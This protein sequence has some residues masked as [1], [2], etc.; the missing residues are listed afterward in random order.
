MPG[1]ILASASGIRAQLL[2][3]AGLDFIAER[4]RIDED[5][6]KRALQAEGTAPRDIADHL[7]ES[8]ALKLAGRNPDA[9]VLGCDQVLEFGN[10]MLSKPGSE[11]EARA[12]ILAMA[13]QTHFLHSAAILIE[14]GQTAWRHVSTVRMT[15][16]A[17]S[18]AY[19]ERYVTRNWSEIRHCVGGYQLE[20]EGSR[21]F[22]RVEGDY[23]AVLGLPLL[24]LLDHLAVKGVIET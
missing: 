22:S 21:L 12:Q 1:L 15:M 13:G 6:L 2:R 11:A 8:K 9:L 19:V 17:L 10:E 3:N 20:A 24:P 7:A 14:A 18:P 16:R 5:S 4:A 23:F